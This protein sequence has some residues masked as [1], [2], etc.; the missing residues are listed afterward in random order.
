MNRL[1]L[2]AVVAVTVLALSPV[3]G[4]G[5]G[6]VIPVSCGSSGEMP[7]AGPN[8]GEGAG[9]NVRFQLSQESGTTEIDTNQ[10][11]TENPVETYI[12]TMTMIDSD[13]NTYTEAYTET[14]I[15]TITRIDSDGNT[16]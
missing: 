15:E 14:Y 16:Y 7:Y 11:G 13:G 1:I 12:E 5:E 2:V 10:V 6:E 3:A 8:F 4:Y 9:E